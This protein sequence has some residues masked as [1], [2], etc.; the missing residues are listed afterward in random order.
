MNWSTLRQR[1]IDWRAFA[2]GMA[3]GLLPV[4]QGL[5]VAVVLSL[6][7]V[8][9]GF[10]PESD[11]WGSA[12]SYFIALLAICWFFALRLAEVAK[13]RPQAYAEFAVG[14]LFVN[15][16]A[17][18]LWLAGDLD[19]FFP[20]ETSTTLADVVFEIIWRPVLVLLMVAVYQFERRRSRIDDV[21][22]RTWAQD[23]GR[24]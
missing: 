19:R 3:Y 11:E 15:E 2:D 22:D 18:L 17:G 14:A 21:N 20:P 7:A 12:L 6:L 9:F 4:V 10:W 24:H 13:Q 1:T 8:T 23:A 16:V 5:V